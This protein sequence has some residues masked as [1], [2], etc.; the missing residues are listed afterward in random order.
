MRNFIN[1]AFGV[2]VTLMYCSQESFG[3]NSGFGIKGGINISNQKI[4]GQGISITPDAN[5]KP[6]FGIFYN[7]MVSEALAIQSEVLYSSQST[8]KLDLGFGKDGITYNYLNIPM[9]LKYYPTGSLNLHAGPQL[10]ILLSGD[11]YNGVSV[12]DEANKVELSF[13]FGLEI[14][15]TQSLG[16]SGR[17]VLGMSDVYEEEGDAHQK[18]RNIQFSLLFAFQK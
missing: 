16:L 18:N 12:I 3:Q 15:L 17:Y 5:I 9:M 1:I 11:E 8:G 6:H 7:T 4:S 13:G 14:Y 2:I 10:G